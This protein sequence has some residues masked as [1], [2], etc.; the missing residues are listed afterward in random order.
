MAKGAQPIGVVTATPAPTNVGTQQL[1]SA[2]SRQ[3]AQLIAAGGTFP[4]VGKG[5]Y[6]YF[7]TLSSAIQARPYVNGTPGL[8]NTYS[9]GTGLNLSDTPFDQVELYNPNAFAVVYSIR[10]G[11]GDFIDNRVIIGG[12]TVQ[13]VA[14][15]TYPNPGGSE[16]TIA[17]NDLSGQS[18]AD[19]NGTLWLALNRIAIVA[20]N[21]A[22]ATD[23]ILQKSGAL[24]N[25]GPGIVGILA[26][27]SLYLPVSG[28]YSVSNGGG[29]NNLTISETYN[30]IPPTFQ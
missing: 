24:T 7:D 1:A 15:P 22:T 20:T 10:V 12:G 19:I 8:F 23:Y 17:I 21:Y 5:S 14:Y 16:A 26:R 30:A 13:A 25:N 27:T 9:Q 4:I 2:S 11:F 28:N 29:V 6:F 18:F 3:V